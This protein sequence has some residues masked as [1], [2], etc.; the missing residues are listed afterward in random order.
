MS[1]SLAA[2]E[3]LQPRSLRE[4]LRMLRDEGGLV[5]LAGATDLY[6]ALAAGAVPARRFL[7]LWRLDGLRRIRVRGDRLSIGALATYAALL[8]SAAVRRQL[9][10]LA[11]A[12]ASVGSLQI[13]NRGTIGGNVGGASAAGDTHPVLAAAGA[14][15][16]LR[17]LGGERRA[18]IRAFLR[19]EGGAARR[20]DE[21][22]V[23]LEVPRVEGAQWFRKV[24]RTLALAAVRSEAPRVALGGVGP[25]VAYAERAASALAAGA[26]EE[27]VRLLD[28]EIDPTDDDRASARYKR[29]VAANLLRRFWQDTVPESAS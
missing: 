9:P 3:L 29:I 15:V 4:A 25:T 16:V 8:R 12:A 19:S 14:D 5:P 17:S 21:L 24:G 11:A 13:R 23:A 27:A 28:L 2:L 7:D 18:P 22:I 26:L 1:T 10:M 6:R 20:P